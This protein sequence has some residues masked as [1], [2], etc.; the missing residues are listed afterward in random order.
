LPEKWSGAVNR[1]VPDGMEEPTEREFA[2]RINALAQTLR[3]LDPALPVR[4]VHMKYEGGLF[5]VH[6]TEEKAGEPPSCQRCDR[7]QSWQLAV[8]VGRKNS[9]ELLLFYPPGAISQFKYPPG[10]QGLIEDPPNGTFYRIG[11]ISN[12]ARL[13]SRGI[14]GIVYAVDR[15]L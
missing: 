7:P 11:K 1:L 6:D 5:E 3:S 9:A 12:P 13:V 14:D 2:M 4:I 15:K 8:V 10:Y